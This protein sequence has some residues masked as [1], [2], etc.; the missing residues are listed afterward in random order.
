MHR[1]T[2]L[3]LFLLTTAA[4]AQPV[5]HPDAELQSKLDYLLADFRGDAG[6]YARHLP[7]GRTA[8]L[9]ADTLFPTASM[10][11]VPILLKTFD[12]IDQ[13]KLAYDQEFVYRDSLLYPGVDLLGSFKDGETISLRALIMLM[14]TMSDNTASLW[15]QHLSGTGTAINEWLEGHGLTGTRMNSRTPGRRP[16]WEKYGWGQTTPR[17]MAEL[18]V[19]IR[20]GRAVSP[21][22]SEQM[23]R[24]LTRPYWNDR[25]IAEIPPSVQAATKNGAVNASR[26]EVV[27][28]NA[29]GGDYV[30]C[31][32]TK[33][34]EDQSWG[35]DN[36]GFVLIRDVSRT[37]WQ[38][39]EPDSEWSP[40][41]GRHESTRDR[42][43]E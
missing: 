40:A 42:S 1:L 11:K 2:L 24:T 31:I 4:H 6:V 20:E 28:V 34:Q 30:F 32:I 13:G 5:E 21:A 37:L 36:D 22:A 26:S 7:T 33:N 3:L 14:I 35:D 19:M 25:A 27:L 16:A 10:I 12:S 43:E 9:N 17:E 39:F 23:Y 18:L 15:L 29:P 8:T 38:H 41:A